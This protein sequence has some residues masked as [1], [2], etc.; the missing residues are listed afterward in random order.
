MPFSRQEVGV[1]SEERLNGDVWNVVWVIGRT[2]HSRY[3]EAH[4]RAMIGSIEVFAVPAGGEGEINPKPRIDR[5]FSGRNN[6][7]D[8]VLDARVTGPVEVRRDA[9]ETHGPGVEALGIGRATAHRRHVVAE[10]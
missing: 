4:V 3:A 7:G 9:I 2:A 8:G 10:N 1:G 5:A 6:I